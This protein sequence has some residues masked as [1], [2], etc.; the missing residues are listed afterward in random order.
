MRTLFLA[1][2]LY[3]AASLG[4]AD[5]EGYRSGTLPVRMRRDVR[6]RASRVV[7]VKRYMVAIR[8]PLATSTRPDVDLRPAFARQHIEVRDQGNRNTCGIFAVTACL[9]FV[10]AT[11]KGFSPGEFSPEYLNYVKNLA[12][13][14]STD[15]GF[16]TEINE[17]YG[18]F[19]IYLEAQVPYRSPYDPRYRVPEAYIALAQNWPRLKPDVI[20]DWDNTKGATDEEVGEICEYLDK[21]IPV[22]AGFMWPKQDSFQTHTIEGV[23]VMVTPRRANVID[24]HSVALVGYRRSPEL[25]GG[26]YFIFRNSWGPDWGDHGH[27]YMPFEYVTQYCNDMVAY[28]PSLVARRTSPSDVPSGPHPVGPRGPN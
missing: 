17:G 21:S 8:P 22:A 18:R 7:P 10:L 3:A 19:G 11:T 1:V 2:A 20:K 9:Q 28:K 12:N 5:T 14:T 16:F 23:E 6:E 26:G 27:G 4:S 24:G 13:H 25:P 15:G